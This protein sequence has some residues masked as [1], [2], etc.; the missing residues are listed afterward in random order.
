MYKQLKRPMYSKSIVHLAF[1]VRSPSLALESVLRSCAPYNR[2][3]LSAHQI[4]FSIHIPFTVCS[5]FIRSDSFVLVPIWRC[6]YQ[7]DLCWQ[8]V[9]Q[10]PHLTVCVSIWSRLTV[11]ISKSSFDGVYIKVPIW[12]YVYQFDLCWRCVYESPH[13]TVCVSIWPRLTVCILKSPFDGMYINMTSVD[14]VYQSPH[15]MCISL[16]M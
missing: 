16:T 8:C 7:F 4:P 9:Y 6:V 5:F 13:L 10:S 15:L 3:S 11:C 14:S 2:C 1:I 12:R